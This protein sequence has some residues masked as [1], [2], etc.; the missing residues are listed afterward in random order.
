[1]VTC[2]VVAGQA[3]TAHAQGTEKGAFGIGIILGEPTG[4]SAK[5]YLSDDTAIAAAVGSA[6]IGGG[7]HLHAD[8]LWHPWVLEEAEHFVLPA[9]V[10]V[11]ARVLDELPGDNRHILHLGLRG[12]G[13]MLFDFKAIPLDV[14]GEVAAVLDFAFDQ[15]RGGVG[16][17]INI[18]LGARYYF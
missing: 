12:V 10:G 1:M 11:G 5:L 4:I 15:E 6:F 14:F 9:Y 13:G 18:G 7:V 16:L 2:L 8:Y 3:R 17:A